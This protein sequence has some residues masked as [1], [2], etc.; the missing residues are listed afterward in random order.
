LPLGIASEV[1]FRLLPI[2][3]LVGAKIKKRSI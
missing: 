2:P 1:Y 3:D